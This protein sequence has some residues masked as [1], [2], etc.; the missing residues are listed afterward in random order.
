MIII[1]EISMGLVQE[2]GIHALRSS[3]KVIRLVEHFLFPKI[4]NWVKYLRQSYILQKNMFGKNYH[5][6]SEDTW[7]SERVNGL[8]FVILFEST[9]L[10]MFC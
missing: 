9:I 8:I 6:S 10:T 1:L 3:Q 4:I 7:G 5:Q 2:M